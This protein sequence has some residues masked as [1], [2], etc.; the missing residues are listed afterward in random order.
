MSLSKR[1]VLFALAGLGASAALPAVAQAADAP[2]LAAGRAI[3]EA[4]RAAHSGADLT[5][6]RNELL[7]GGFTAE[8]GER[9]RARVSAD[10]RAARVF[11]FKGWRLSETEAQLFALLTSAS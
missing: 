8:A 2:D 10:F 11:I 3:G 4:Y 1:D 5:R 9:L 7:P 6:L